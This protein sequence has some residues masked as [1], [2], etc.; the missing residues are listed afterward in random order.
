MERWDDLTVESIC[1]EKAFTDY[2]HSFWSKFSINLE[3]SHDAVQYSQT[4]TAYLAAKSP[5]KQF[6][7]DLGIRTN[8]FFMNRLTNRVT[9]SKIDWLNFSNYIDH[10]RNLPASTKSLNLFVY[11]YY[12]M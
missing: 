5:S 10:Q 12:I 2:I 11:K 6:F 3:R 8:N 1:E 7:K 4:W 9:H